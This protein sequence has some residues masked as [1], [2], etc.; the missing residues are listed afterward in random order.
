MLL[1]Q[2]T[3]LLE[4]ETMMP[5][6]ETNRSH[7]DQYFRRPDV[8][9]VNCAYVDTITNPISTHAYLVRNTQKLV[10]SGKTLN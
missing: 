9:S 7:V 2:L 10:N 3:D 1:K 5:R 6:S 8:G 4:P